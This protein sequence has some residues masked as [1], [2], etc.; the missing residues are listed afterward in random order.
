MFTNVSQCH[1]AHFQFQYEMVPQAA[2]DAIYKDI[3]VISRSHRHKNYRFGPVLAF[4]GDIYRINS[5]I[6]MKCTRL[7]EAYQKCHVFKVIH[8]TQGHKGI[9]IASLEPIFVFLNDDSIFY[10]QRPT[11]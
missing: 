9:K 6:T 2:K 10:S 8:A 7:K 4:P 1:P 3:H 11:K 5:Q